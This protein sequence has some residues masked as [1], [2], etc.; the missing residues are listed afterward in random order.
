MMADEER[1]IKKA[2]EMYH[3][4]VKIIEHDQINQDVYLPDEIWNEME[5]IVRFIKGD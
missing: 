2:H 3:L 5:Y 1:L 4:I